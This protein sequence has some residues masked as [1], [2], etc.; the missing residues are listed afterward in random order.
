MILAW[1]VGCSHVSGLF[2]RRLTTAG[3][4][5]FRLNRSLSRYRA[6]VAQDKATGFPVLAYSIPP[7]LYIIT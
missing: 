6:L 1:R 4:D 2:A 7:L 3:P 5:V